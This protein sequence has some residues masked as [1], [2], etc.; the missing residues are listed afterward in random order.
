VHHE[1]ARALWGKR[2]ASSQFPRLP[3]LD[4]HSHGLYSL[5]MADNLRHNWRQVIGWA[6]A[7]D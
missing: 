4:C 6:I 5:G 2:D 1:A 3:P 7:D